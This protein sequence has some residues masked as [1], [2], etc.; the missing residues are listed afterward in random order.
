MAAYRWHPITDLP[1]DWNE[2][3]SD[4]LRS[5]SGVWQEQRA[6]L[7]GGH[8]FKQFNERLCRQWA[9]E[10]GIIEG[11]Y[12]IDRGTTEL[13]IEHGLVEEMLS[14]GSTNR[15]AHEVIQ[16]LRDQQDALEGLFAFITQQRD[17]STSYIKE[18]HSALT[19][20]QT[21]VDARDQFGTA[22]RAPVIRGDWK[23]MPNNPTRPDGE[24]HE[25]AP[26]EQVASEMD[27]LVA[28]HREHSAQGV[29]PEIEAAW[30]HHRFTQIHP[31]QDG[32]GR[33]ARALASLIF[34]RAGWFPLVVTR[35]DRAAYIQALERS[36][37]SDLPGLVTLFVKIQKRAFVQALSLSD[38]VLSGRESASQVIS[39]ARDRLLARQTARMEEWTR[40]LERA[41][42]MADRLS[43]IALH[44]TEEL[45]QEVNP[46]L[47][48]VER[49]YRAY[50][51]RSTDAN[52][53]WYHYQV[54]SAARDLGYFADTRWYASWVRLRLVEER[55]TDIFVSLHS[56]GH[57]PIGV[58]AA[59][60]FIEFRD[61]DR[62][63]DEEP[64]VEGP[65]V[66]CEEVFQFA[67]NEGAD[68]VERRFREWLDDSLVAGLDQ[69][70]RQL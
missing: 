11:L 51:Q 64:R 24:I 36:D 31:F 34:L 38:Q 43:D 29:P 13:L 20:H 33:V 66:L 56:L 23:Q 54:V 35:D 26:P 46:T 39:A 2:F 47:Q 69:W 27:R 3:A 50:A 6:R 49:A 45:A 70:R 67:H 5:L 44:A 63:D 17:L 1:R 65:Y 14:H 48:S 28:M 41:E 62:S 9:I 32:N 68:A 37:T 58:M 15:P 8:A 52:S 59:S 19:R 12:D 25:Y 4:E 18:V 53:G 7:E 22:V 21:H 60:A 40:A 30:L 57:E 61:R 55:Q 16:V 42:R 10:T